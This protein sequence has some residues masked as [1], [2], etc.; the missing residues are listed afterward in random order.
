ME[1][2]ITFLLLGDAGVTALVGN[3]VHWLRLPQSVG[4]KPYINLQRVTGRRDY[5]MQGASGL[6]SSRLQIDAWGETYSSAK[7]SARAV[8][9]ALSGYR[10]IVNGTEIQGGFVDTERDL[11]DADA[12]DV[13]RLY[14][15]SVDIEIWHSE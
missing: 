9:A 15:V 14:R 12:G 11:N 3:R 2:A 10:G 4:E 5:R 8:I 6:V 1:E 13:N 7:H